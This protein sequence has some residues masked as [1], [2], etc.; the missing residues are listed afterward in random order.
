[1]KSLAKN[2]SMLF[3]ALVALSCSK[4][5]LYQYPSSESDATAITGFSLVNE[6]AAS[7][8]DGAAAI[9]RAAGTVTVK[10][11]AGTDLTRLYPRATVSEGVMVEPQMGYATNFTAPVQ[12]RLTA[13]DRKTVQVWTVTVVF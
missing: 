7:V 6:A 11:V 8:I 4:S 10:A 1:M 9:D 2:I 13:G 3:L 12:Y 5:E